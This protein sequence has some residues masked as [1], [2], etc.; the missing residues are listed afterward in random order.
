MS[1]VYFHSPS[2]EAELNGSEHSHLRHVARG[3]AVAA[4]DL[5]DRLDDLE[6][7]AAILA[8]V[9]DD[10]TRRGNYLHEDLRKA[11]AEQARHRAA[12]EAGRWGD[13]DPTPLH[14]L[15]SGL[16]TSL[17]VDRLRLL[18]AG[19]ELRTFN[20]ELNTAI[21]V[22]SE[23][24]RLAAKIAGY[25]ESHCWVEGEDRAWLAGVI[26]AGL[27]AGI[28]R[29]GLWYV[30]RVTDVPVEECPDR[31]WLTQGWENVTAFLRSRDDEPVVL[32]YSVTEGF[33]N[34]GVAGWEP[35]PMPAGWAPDWADTDAGRAE[36]ETDHPDDES[37]REYYREAAADLWYELDAGERWRQAMD[38]L[39]ENR[40]WAQLSPDMLGK[41]TFHWPVTVYDLLAPDRDERVRAAVASVE[42]VGS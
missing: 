6:Q 30:N 42:V 25:C 34:A 13:Y 37:R 21:V 18:V 22:G 36:W 3:P 9:P 26:D 32:S 10:P 17:A 27:A 2:G 24:V 12:V 39:R 29:R 5:G 11:Q 16:K 33:P 8:M 1:R 20:V 14:R 15:V 35:P 4:W 31:R 41:L 23:P 28:F 40:P 38:G 7:A 19:H